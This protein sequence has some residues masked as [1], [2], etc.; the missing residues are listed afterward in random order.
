MVYIMA[1]RVQKARGHSNWPKH[2]C[3]PVRA[4]VNALEKIWYPGQHLLI[5]SP[6]PLSTVGD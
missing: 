2:G 4:W 5:I 1:D 3:K 6:A